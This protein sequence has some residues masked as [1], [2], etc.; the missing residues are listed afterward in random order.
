VRSDSSA[1]PFCNPLAYINS[2]GNIPHDLEVESFVEQGELVGNN[3]RVVVGD[4]T[5]LEA[6]ALGLVVLDV[7]LEEE[8]FGGEAC[9]DGLYQ[10]S[11]TEV[12][13]SSEQFQVIDY[14]SEW[15]YMKSF[16]TRT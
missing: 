4:F 13:C 16:P 3:A 10:R 6:V 1:C 2:I 15:T 5:D 7:V 9:T 14:F 11:H 8:Y 12:D